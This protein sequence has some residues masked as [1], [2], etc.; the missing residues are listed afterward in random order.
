M[1]V[2][3]LLSR[4][5]ILKIEKGDDICIG[6]KSRC[7]LHPQCI[8]GEDEDGCYEEYLMNGL[9][10]PSQTFVCPSPYHKIVKTNGDKAKL[11]TKRAVPCDANKECPGGEDEDC[12]IDILVEILIRK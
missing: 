8:G 10:T 6:P 7:D 12:D 4:N 5:H 1:G 2:W 3:Q 11:F 9:V